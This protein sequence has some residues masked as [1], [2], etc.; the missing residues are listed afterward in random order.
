MTSQRRSTRSVHAHT[1][2]APPPRL[3]RLQRS[4]CLQPTT[5]TPAASHV[6]QVYEDKMSGV[7]A[8]LFHPRC[9]TCTHTMPALSCAQLSRS[10]SLSLS[11]SRSRTD[12][13]ATTSAS[14]TRAMVLSPVRLRSFSIICLLPRS[15]SRL[16]RIISCRLGPGHGLARLDVVGRR[17][18]VQVD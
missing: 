17:R 14:P 16:H 15:Y 6:L 3:S 8:P 13:S 9:A 2:S 10:H 7:V 5:L 18:S 12:S 1:R 4:S 11:C